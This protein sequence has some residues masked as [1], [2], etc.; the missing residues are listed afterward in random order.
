M[1]LTKI[2]RNFQLNKKD[3]KIKSELCKT[4]QEENTC[5]SREHFVK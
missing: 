1:L 4:V 2:E 3:H 5:F